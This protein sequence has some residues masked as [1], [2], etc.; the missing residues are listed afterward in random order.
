MITAADLLAFNFRFDNVVSPSPL[1]MPFAPASFPYI[2]MKSQLKVQMDFSNYRCT[3]LHHGGLNSNKSLVFS[4]PSYTGIIGYMPK[5][6]Y[7]FV[8]N[9]GYPKDTI[10]I[11]PEDSST[12]DRFLDLSA[13]KYDL[14]DERHMNIRQT[15]LPRLAVLYSYEVIEEETELLGRL[16]SDSFDPHHAVLLSEKPKGGFSGQKEKIAE[17]I[18]LNQLN[19]DEVVGTFENQGPAIV[20]FSES[21]DKGW[22]AFVDGREVPVYPANYNFM[23]GLVDAGRHEVRFKYEPATFYLAAKIAVFGLGIFILGVMAGWVRRKS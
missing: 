1:H 14:K 23:A 10:L 7:N 2:D 12:S 21:Y 8:V 17:P 3:N 9:F 4:I 13:V 16:G 20:L 19:S 22:K 18:L 5:R 15:A 6:F 11:Y